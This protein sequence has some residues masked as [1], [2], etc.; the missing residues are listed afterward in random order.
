M[1]GCSDQSHHSSVT[2]SANTAQPFTL[3]PRPAG[4]CEGI[5]CIKQSWPAA[6]R[7]LFED[8]DRFETVYFAPFQ[9]GSG[10]A[11]GWRSLLGVQ[12]ACL[13]VRG[14]RLGSQLH[15]LCTVTAQC[16]CVLL[17]T[18]HLSYRAKSPVWDLGAAAA[19]DEVSPRHY[20][21]YITLLPY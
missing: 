14:L 9:V 21:T 13:S 10:R 16:D 2:T 6:I 17:S 18:K 11:C 4:P 3:M 7:T 15:W 19:F 12:P 1:R 8:Q 20:Y 5:L